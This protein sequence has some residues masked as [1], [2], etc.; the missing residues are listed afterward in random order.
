MGGSTNGGTQKSNGL[1]ENPI[2]T[3]DLRLPPLME[4]P[5]YIMLIMATMRKYQETSCR[6]LRNPAPVGMMG[7]HPL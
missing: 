3:D 2:K 6:W 4:T 1:V 5:M 7:K